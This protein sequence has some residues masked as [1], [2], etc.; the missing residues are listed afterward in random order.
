MIKKMPKVGKNEESILVLLFDRKMDAASLART[1]VSTLWI[2]SVYAA[3][4][5]MKRKGLVE[6][7]FEEGNEHSGKPRPIY[8]ITGLGCVVLQNSYK[9]IQ[10]RLEE[11]KDIL[12]KNSCLDFIEL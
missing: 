9:E 4:R 6:V 12:E 11:M 10:V 2:N 8:G 1:S 3:L 5:Q 7:S